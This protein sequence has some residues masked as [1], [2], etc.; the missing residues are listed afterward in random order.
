MTRVL[1]PLVAASL[2]WFAAE[3]YAS[4]QDDPAA[5][6]MASAI[7]D[8]RSQVVSATHELNALR[9]RIAA[10]RKPLSEDL[11]SYQSEAERLRQEVAGMRATRDREQAEFETLAREVESLRKEYEFDFTL[12]REYRR[13]FEARQGVAESQVLRPRL[14]EID[15]GLG[16]GEHSTNLVSATGA[17]LRLAEEWNVGMVGGGLFEGTC[18]DVDGTERGGSFVILGPASYFS[19]DSGEMAGLVVNLAGS[20][21]PSLFPIPGPRPGDAI[22]TLVQGGETELPIDFTGGDALKVAT[23]RKSPSQRLAAGGFVMVPLLLIGGA[24]AFLSIMKIMTLRGIQAPPEDVLIELAGLVRAERMD[25][26]RALVEPLQV[27]Y[28]PVLDSAIE[29]HAVPPDHLEEIMHERALATIPT[30]D[31]HLGMLAVLGGVAPLL[32][33]LGTVT[34]MIHTFELVTIFGT[35]DAKLLSGGITEALVT[36]ETGLMIAVPVL[37][38]HAYLSRKVRGIVSSLE[39]TV[40]GFMN[41]LHGQEADA[42]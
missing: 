2:V 6:R 41:R 4:A 7:E 25:E 30:L 22:A 29:Y 33:L 26:A 3:P 18:L 40:V 9:D 38:V 35:G 15:R 28:R 17:L 37:L 14:L 23:G 42:S 10:L 24:A 16:T 8:A 13:S 32:G 11:E 36:T 39:Q 5:V 34:G 12:L 27:P 31:R 19:D 21:R 1:G 20:R